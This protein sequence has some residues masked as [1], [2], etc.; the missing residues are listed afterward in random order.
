MKLI[1]C[2]FLC[3][4]T[5]STYA[6]YKQ[7]SSL[8]MSG[9]SSS[10]TIGDSKYYISSSVGQ[11]SVIGTIGNDTFTMR[12]GFQQPPIRVMAMPDSNSTIEA[13]V[14]PNPVDNFVTVVLGSLVETDI[15]SILYDIQGRLITTN[16]IAPTRSFQV[17]MS[18]L[19]S[20]TYILK[21]II[22]SEG[23]ST[24]LIKN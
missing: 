21:I 22:A 2:L 12:Q 14:Y 18:L 20:G 3:V 7:R 17:D 5:G 4:L 23:F 8:G 16:I 10:I 15:V 11:K 24:R 13:V 9:S 1:I 19:A 6:Q